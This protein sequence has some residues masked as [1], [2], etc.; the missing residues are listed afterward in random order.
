MKVAKSCLTCKCH[1]GDKSR[2]TC[3]CHESYKIMSY[4]YAA[5]FSMNEGVCQNMFFCM[6]VTLENVLFRPVQHE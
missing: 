4:L 2:L 5:A 6:I 1:E 3:M